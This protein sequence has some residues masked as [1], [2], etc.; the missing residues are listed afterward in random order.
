MRNEIIEKI[1]ASDNLINLAEM[2]IT[3]EE[4]ANL[5][6]ENKP[7]VQKIFLSCNY[8]GDEGAVVLSRNLSSLKYL[9]FLDVQENQI[10]IEGIF[11]LDK[12]IHANS[13][14]KVAV[15]GNKVTD[16]KVFDELKKGTFK[17]ERSHLKP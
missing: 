11:A 2:E 7:Y 13:N 10:D 4:I 1:N 5:I 17:L 9:A 15:S 6:V 8:L 14:L 12:L 3:D 16:A